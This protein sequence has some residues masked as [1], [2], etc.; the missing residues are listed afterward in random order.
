MTTIFIHSCNKYLTEIFYVPDRVL[1]AENTHWIQQTESLNSQF[2]PLEDRK[3]M[4][5]RRKM[6]LMN[7]FVGQQ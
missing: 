3:K 4:T 7:L 5:I 2:L 1:D 6:V